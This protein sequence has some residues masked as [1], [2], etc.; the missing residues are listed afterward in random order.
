M[1]GIRH[2]LVLL[3]AATFAVAC[4]SSTLPGSTGLGG[5]GLVSAAV[6][7]APAK[8]AAVPVPHTKAAWQA[9]LKHIRTPG[10]G[11]FSSSYPALTWHAVK[12]GT[13][14][15][16]PAG[17]ARST[18]STA[19]AR[20]AQ[21]GG[22]TDGQDYVTTVPGYISEATGIFW[23]VDSAITEQGQIGGTGPQID[24]AF[25]LQMN[26]N[27]HFATAA[28]ATSSNLECTGWQ[29]FLY[30][31]GTSGSTFATPQ[32]YMQYWLF[33]YGAAATPSTCPSSKWTYVAA[34]GTT[35]LAGCF[36]NSKAVDVPAV[37]ATD[38]D[39]VMFTGAA[40]SGGNDEVQLTV[41]EETYAFAAPD[42]MLDL[43]AVWNQTQWGVYGDA[44]NGEAN[45]GEDTSLEAQTSLE[46][47]SGQPTI[48]C[49]EGNF[50]AESNNLNLTTT[51]AIGNQGVLQDASE[52]TTGTAGTPSCSIG[53]VAPTQAAGLATDALTG[54]WQAQSDLDSTGSPQPLPTTT[55]DCGNWSDADGTQVV[56]LDN[57][58]DLWSFGDT[59]LGPAVARQ[60]FFNNSDVD[61][62]MVVQDGSTFTTITGGTG[63]ASG[64]PTVAS[65]P[66]TASG[67]GTIWPASSIVYGSDVEKF[68]YTVNADLVQ[69]TPEV[70]EIPQSDLESGDTYSAQASALDGCV[71]GDPIMWGA[72]TVAS[73]GYTYIYGSQQFSGSAGNTGGEGGD[74][75]LARSA[76]DPSDQGTWEYYTAGGWSAEGASCDGLTLSALGG[77]EPIVVP[78]E[79]SVTYV[80]GD[81]WL[82]DEDPANGNEPGWAV[83]HEAAT[84]TGFTLD[85]AP[86]VDLFQP[87]QTAFSGI[88]DNVS[89]LTHYS[90][91]MMDPTAVTASQ[92]DSVV[93][94][95]NVNDSYVDAGCIPLLDYDA[96]A[97]RPRF[98]DVPISDLTLNPNAASSALDEPAPTTASPA[99][100]G[101]VAAPPAPIDFSPQVAAHGEAQLKSA[102]LTGSQA[103]AGAPWTYNP[104]TVPSNATWGSTCL[105]SR[106]AVGPID[107][108]QNQDGSIEV[109]WKYQ[110]PD[111][112]YWFHWQDDTS[113]PGVW[114]ENELWTEGPNAEG[115]LVAPPAGATASNTTSV[116]QLFTLPSGTNPGDQ[117]SFWVQAF[118]AGNGSA[119]SPDSSANATSDTPASPTE[120][121]SGITATAG[122]NAVT[123]NW[124]AAPAPIAGQA[125]WYSVRYM[126]LAES[127]WTY[128]TDYISNTADMT[129]LFGGE[130]YE[131]EVAVTDAETNLATAAWSAPILATPNT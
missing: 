23:E 128:T 52:Q 94:A 101:Q 26:S 61:N 66:I 92:S 63:C 72:A 113:D 40:T 131:F 87:T 7:H 100:L 5:T 3:T 50:T 90:V 15:R 119:V 51:P 93:I 127:A 79:F 115:Y 46:V 129:P 10:S 22:R 32:I 70:A 9:D 4:L 81:F 21:V 71:S 12:C 109:Y 122:A 106:P 80:N 14:P 76:G 45:F 123:L 38:L 36:I 118:A 75:Y 102:S 55:A 62:S 107:F 1:R 2:R 56:G 37:T 114:N 48:S 88:D 41:G 25:S 17:G 89:G 16:V 28:C 53:T 116:Y 30:T 108:V 110:G 35:S 54:A 121:V 95:Y 69:Q 73:G 86:S 29:Q 59:I 67:G 6:H 42:S 96:N 44:G 130:E 78:T 77:T 104:D 13:A 64:Q 99:T 58:D 24:N 27:T 39:A 49:D 68:Y 34:Q 18:T 74:L 83:A 60:D 33:N 124:T 31:Y 57:G 98:V 82:V 105:T 117:F 84:P 47:S 65:A 125:I 126:T 8:A 11:C 120:T 43:A 103:A 97:Y 112:W 19:H 20:P 111:V 85:P 91:R